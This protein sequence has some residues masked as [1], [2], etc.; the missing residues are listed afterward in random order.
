MKEYEYVGIQ[1]I[2]KYE[3]F[4]I[5]KIISPS[6]AIN[7]IAAKPYHIGILYYKA[8]I[9]SVSYKQRFRIAKPYL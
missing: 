4:L 1:Y 8:F 7:N 2:A 9:G 6:T 3:T 5:L